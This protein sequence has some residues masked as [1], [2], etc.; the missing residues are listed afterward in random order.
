EVFRLW[1]GLGYYNRAKNMLATA[2]YLCKHHEGK[3]PQTYQELLKLKG[4][5]KYTAAA[6]ASFAFNERVAVLDGNVYRV[7]ARYFGIY[8]DINSSQGEKEFRK[9]A[10]SLVPTQACE[11]NQAIMD[12][13]ALQCTP[14]KPNCMFCPL[15]ENCFAF[16]YQE[17]TNLP[18]KISKVQVKKRFFAYIVWHK[19]DKIAMKKRL[20][21]DIWQNLYDFDL[22]EKNSI[23]ELKQ[24][25]IEQGNFL[26]QSEIFKHQLTH[27]TIFIR[28]FHVE[29]VEGI[30]LPLN[31]EWH[32]WEEVEHLPKP[33]VIADYITT[34][35]QAKL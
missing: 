30:E 24:F 27:Q 26:F 2:R 11:Y 7:L 18:V 31:I 25:T 14:Q 15:Q 19:D 16:A 29:H 33:I 12:F 32:T 35:R 28:F 34:L 6:I 23:E 5:G 20:S 4:I 13:G 8:T 22:Q 10:Q 9:L 17:Q 1:Q 3:F 21:K